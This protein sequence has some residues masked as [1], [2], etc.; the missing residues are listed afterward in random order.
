[1]YLKRNMSAVDRT[2]RILIAII[3]GVLYFTNTITGVVG[4]ILLVIGII[5]LLTSIVG[6]CPLYAL[7]GIRTKSKISEE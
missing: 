1:M 7:L 5:L 6:S 4:G 2:I 3:L